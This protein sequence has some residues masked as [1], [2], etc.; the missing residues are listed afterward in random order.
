[1]RSAESVYIERPLQSKE[2]RRLHHG[3]IKEASVN[4]WPGGRR[5]AMDQTKH[6][7]W[8][9]THYPG[10]RQLC[11]QCEEP[12]GRCEEDTIRSKKDEPLCELCF[13]NENGGN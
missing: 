5:H 3:A 11:S 10:T 9:A 1:M 4:T 12:T 6:E 8:N 7:K 13:E 2:V